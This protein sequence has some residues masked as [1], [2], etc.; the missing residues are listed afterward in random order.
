MF[1]A[2]PLNAGAHAEL[3]RANMAF[4]DAREEA[5]YRARYENDGGGYVH[6]GDDADVHDPLRGS[7]TSSGTKY[8]ACW[9][10]GKEGPPLKLCRRCLG[11]TYCSRCVLK[12]GAGRGG[13][14]RRGGG[15]IVC[16]CTR[17]CAIVLVRRT[18]CVGKGFVD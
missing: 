8:I 3:S 11:A 1:G 5:W 12:K 17:R 18:R 13:G 15:S 4:N 2:S 9:G 10:C 16:R 14:A 7:S 6:G